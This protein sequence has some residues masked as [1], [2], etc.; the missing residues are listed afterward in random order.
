M[1]RQWCCRRRLRRWRWLESS[2]QIIQ[3]LLIESSRA[4]FSESCFPS[5]P[6][7]DLLNKKKMCGKCV[8]MFLSA[9]Y[10]FAMGER[11]LSLSLCL[12]HT[13]APKQTQEVEKIVKEINIDVGGGAVVC[14]FYCLTN[15]TK[16][17]A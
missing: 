11:S 8:E 15:N 4:R 6:Q 16:R 9:H 1:Y 2:F 7:I 13:L 12:S 10:D 5:T 17:S 14:L 3:F